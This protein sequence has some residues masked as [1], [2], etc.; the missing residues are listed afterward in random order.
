MIIDSYL[1]SVM[2]VDIQN[3]KTT[4]AEMP[5]IALYAQDA[6]LYQKCALI[7]ALLYVV[8]FFMSTKKKEMEECI[9]VQT[10]YF[11]L[12]YSRLTAVIVSGGYQRD[13]LP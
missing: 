7:Y 9:W 10:F 12:E 2:G 13:I 8:V 1:R 6:V 3:I 4:I 11:V 5:V